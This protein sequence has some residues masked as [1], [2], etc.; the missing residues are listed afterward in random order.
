[1]KTYT[2]FFCKI[3]TILTD[4]YTLP[5]QKGDLQGRHVCS[6][7]I[8]RIVNTPGAENAESIDDFTTV[9]CDVCKGTSQVY[10]PYSSNH[11]DHCMSCKTHGWKF[12]Y[13]APL[14][15][16]AGEADDGDRNQGQ[17]N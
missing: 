8:G 6:G 14:E 3:D 1:M 2:C 9:V 15:R 5:Y 11:K 16:L 13:L 4:G 12:R 17:A 10:A 7:C